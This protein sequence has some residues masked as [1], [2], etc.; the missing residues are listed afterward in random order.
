MIDIFG[1]ETIRTIGLYQPFASLMHHG[2]IETRWVKK[3]KKPPFP[4]GKY[5]L[6]STLK[7][8]SDKELD[9]ICGER[10]F[11]R[12]MRSLIHDA[13]IKLR[14]YAIS[15]SKVEVERVMEKRKFN[16]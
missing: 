8:Y 5:I 6:Y 2:K 1:N 15:T 4:L 16:G 10:Q 13:T 14:G 9:Y 7:S 3:G 12:I 11:V